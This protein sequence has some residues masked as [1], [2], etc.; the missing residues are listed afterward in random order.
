[1]EKKMLLYHGSPE[2]II[3]D[4]DMA[5]NTYFTED[6][7]IAKDYG[8]YIYKIETDEKMIGLFTKDCM[9]E[10]WINRGHI[11]LYLFD[12]I[13]TGKDGNVI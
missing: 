12:V 5:S 4:R 1:M 11:P 2:L 6:I 8:K 10:H 3:N 7:E 9:N 13:E